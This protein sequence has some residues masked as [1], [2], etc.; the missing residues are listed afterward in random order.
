M[1]KY[2]PILVVFSLALL[3]QC[4]KAENLSG[5]GKD[6]FKYS[7][8]TNEQ[9][10]IEENKF[11]S[12]KYLDTL[13]NQLSGDSLIPIQFTGQDQVIISQLVPTNMKMIEQDGMTEYIITKAQFLPDTFT[14]AVKKY[15]D[16]QFLILYS[17]NSATRV[18][19]LKNSGVNLPEIRTD[20]QPQLKISGYSVGDAVKRDELDIIYSD[21]FGSRVTEEAYLVENADIKLTILGYQYIEKIKKTNIRDQELDPLIR[22]IDKIFSR[23]HEYEEIVNGVDDFKETV[24]GYYWNEKDVSIF[25]QK[26]ERSYEDQDDDRWTLEYSNYVITTILQNYLEVSAENI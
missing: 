21:A 4:K 20:Y 24:K 13:N 12:F 3:S 2:I 22:S 5:L 23:D 17:N 26:I 14:F 18:Y 25:L 19:E 15:I 9:V 8:S 1:N 16:K 7:W 11:H 6:I 10:F